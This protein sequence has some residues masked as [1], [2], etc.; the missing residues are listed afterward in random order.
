VAAGRTE[1]VPAL[2]QPAV[3]PSCLASHGA[4]VWGATATQVVLK[5]RDQPWQLLDLP[6]GLH[7]VATPSPRPQ[8]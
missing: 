3:T 1:L 6:T 5:V 8:H 4:L 7:A 2:D